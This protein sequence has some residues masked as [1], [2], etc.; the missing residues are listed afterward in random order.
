M[1]SVQP[2]RT[3]MSTIPEVK[4]VNVTTRQ[5][6]SFIN[7]A[8][9]THLEKLFEEHHNKELPTGKEFLS[10]NE[11]AEFFSISLTSLHRWVNQGIMKPYKAG[12][13]TYFKHIELLA[14]L[15]NSNRSK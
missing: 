10:R 1:G 12:N 9:Q 15:E 11:T 13:K 7:E 2:K 14:I 8:I 4:I 5:L 3:P 6:G